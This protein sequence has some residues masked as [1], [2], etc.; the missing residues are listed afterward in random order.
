MCHI[1]QYYSS[2]ISLVECVSQSFPVRMGNTNSTSPVHCNRNFVSNSYLLTCRKA[3][4]LTIRR[5][6]G[7]VIP[8]PRPQRSKRNYFRHWRHL[9]IDAYFICH[10]NCFSLYAFS[11][12]TSCKSC[13]MGTLKW[14]AS[15]A[16]HEQLA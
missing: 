15:S 11:G 6:L 10:Y 12:L 4:V 2:I 3:V 14:H 1:N 8:G 7:T 13:F 9:L 5:R 16:R